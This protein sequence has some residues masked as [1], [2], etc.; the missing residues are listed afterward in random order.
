MLLHVVQGRNVFNPAALLV[1]PGLHKRALASCPPGSSGGD[2]ARKLMT[3]YGVRLVGDAEDGCK[4]RT[5]QG[6][7]IPG[8]PG[9]AWHG[10][11]GVLAACAGGGPTPRNS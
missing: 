2:L 11:K 1:P 3:G 8:A 5:S 4:P 6:L 9:P 10:E 7:G